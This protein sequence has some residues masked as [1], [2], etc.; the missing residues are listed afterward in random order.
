M[1]GDSVVISS[2]I[3]DLRG[4]M[5][6]LNE[7]LPSRLSGRLIVCVGVYRSGSTWAYNMVQSI[8]QAALPG[9]RIGGRFAENIDE[10]ALSSADNCDLVVLKTHPQKSLLSLIEFLKPPVILSVRDPRDC[11]ASWMQMLGEDFGVFQPRLMRSCFAALTLAEQDYTHTIRYEDG[12]TASVRTVT[13]IAAHLGLS[14]AEHRAAALVKELSSESVKEQIRQMADAGRIDP[15]ERLIGDAKTLWLP[16]HVGDGRTGKYREALSNDQVRSVNCWS[17]AYCE[18]FGYDVPAPFPIP[19][20]SSS[21]LFGHHSD[22]LPYLRAGFSFPEAGFTW[23]DGDQAIIALPLL[24]PVNGHV[25][26][27]FRYFK[28]QPKSAPPVKLIVML[29]CGGEVIRTVIDASECPTIRFDLDDKRLY[30]TQE[31]LFRIAVVNSYCPK[32]HNDNNDDRWLGM[33][34]QAILLTY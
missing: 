23:T 10:L 32:A 19:R 12:A 33:A 22:A 6:S 1:A 31:L 13:D 17:R 16:A 25:T 26:C 8:I 15:S 21:L 4:P 11:V 34:L 28:P 30:G 18:V 14:I 5:P 20:G 9:V 27:E 2:R 24:V 3:G 7:I 29:L